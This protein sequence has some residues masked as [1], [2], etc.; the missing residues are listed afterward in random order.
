MSITVAIFINAQAHSIAAENGKSDGISGESNK[1][2]QDEQNNSYDEFARGQR[3]WTDNTGEH[4]VV[5]QFVDF[6][7]GLVHLKKKNNRDTYLPLQKLSKEDRELVLCFSKAAKPVDNK[8]KELTDVFEAI[9]KG[10]PRTLSL[11]DW[12]Y[13]KEVPPKSHDVKVRIGN[14]VTE[15][16]AL[17][18]RPTGSDSV[19]NIYWGNQGIN[20]VYGWVADRASLGLVTSVTVKPGF[21]GK[22]YGLKLGEGE[23]QARRLWGDPDFDV[24]QYR[25][26][27]LEKHGVALLVE[28]ENGNIQ[29]LAIRYLGKKYPFRS[30]DGETGFPNWQ[31]SP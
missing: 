21:D 1:Q 2:N 30:Y 12:T 29:E 7:N 10:Y 13:P 17:L 4:T 18:G 9:N 16:V 11:P 19:G 31:T 26:W 27:R 8:L 22:F 28:V 23:A 24:K 14:P 3:K 15:A 25:L 5:A 6:S 20:V